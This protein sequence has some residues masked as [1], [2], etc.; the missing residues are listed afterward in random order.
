MTS[1]GLQHVQASDE[2]SSQNTFHNPSQ[3]LVEA[4]VDSDMPPQRHAGKVG[5]GPNYNAGSVS[6][7]ISISYQF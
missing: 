5:Y 3:A 7:N 6:I 4:D 2:S 1:T